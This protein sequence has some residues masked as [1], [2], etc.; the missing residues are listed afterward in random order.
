MPTEQDLVA[1]LLD[2]M[3]LDEVARFLEQFGGYRVPKRSEAVERSLTE[4][5]LVACLLGTL[6]RGTRLSDET[7]RAVGEQFRMSPK[8]VKHRW[9]AFRANRLETKPVES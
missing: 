3:S 6:T 7:A 4:R 8:A 9:Y 2:R 5:V 1:F